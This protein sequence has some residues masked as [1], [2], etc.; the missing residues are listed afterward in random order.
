MVVILTLAIGDDFRKSLEPALLSKKLYA[1][2]HGYTYIQGGESYWDRERPIPWS[3][4]DFVLE[5]LKDWPD[6]TL[7]SFRMQTL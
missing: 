5:T 3:K 6:G 2:K 4:V 1:E 7:F